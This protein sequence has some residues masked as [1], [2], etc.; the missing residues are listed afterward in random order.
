MNLINELESNARTLFNWSTS[1]KLANLTED[2][3]HQ[4]LNYY[5]ETGYNFTTPSIRQD[6]LSLISDIVYVSSK[7]RKELQEALRYLKGK[8]STYKIKLSKSTEELRSF[9]FKT[10]C[11]FSAEVPRGQKELTKLAVVYSL[12]R[13]ELQK[14]LKALR[15]HPVHAQKLKEV[16][17]NQK[18]V[19][20]REILVNF[21][22][23]QSHGI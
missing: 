5:K 12:T 4:V 2:E 21:T 6:L 17:L 11:R 10:T 3:I 14:E 7:N 19:K 22:R 1:Q 18:T 20:L 9:L 8:S 13:Q 15:S 23:N 16:K